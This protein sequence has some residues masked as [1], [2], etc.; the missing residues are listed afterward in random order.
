MFEDSKRTQ[1]LLVYAS[2]ASCLV[3]ALV[4]AAS[5]HQQFKT[6]NAQQE[7][8]L[9]ETFFEAAIRTAND[10]SSEQP[11]QQQQGQQEQVS[12]EQGQERE[13][14]TDPPLGNNFVWQ[15][16][17]SS[18]SVQ[19]R[20]DEETQS[21]VILPIRDDEAIYSGILTFQASRPVVA[22]VLNLL[23]PGNTTAIP[24]EFGD[25]NDIVRLD[26]GLVSI[27]EVASGSSGSVPFTGSAIGLIADEENEPFLAT[28]SANAVPTQGRIINDITSIL[29]FN[30]SASPVDEAEGEGEGE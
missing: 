24:E 18:Q 2:V 27:S 28:Y 23:K 5:F 7:Q 29:N 4:T 30:A 14:I 6:L 11:E 19:L 16:E 20:E 15:G 26:G 10:T 21:A 12:P 3:L 25:L 8:Q 1:S 22:V 13:N 17:I 9:Q